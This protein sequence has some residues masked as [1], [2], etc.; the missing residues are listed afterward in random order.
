VG[1]LPGAADLALDGVLGVAGADAA[2][3]QLVARLGPFGNGNEE[4]LFVLPRVRVVKSERIGKDHATIRA[5]VAGEAGGQIKTLLFRAGEGALAAALSAVGGPP[6][7]LAG[8]LRAESWNGSVSAGFFV[9]D[10]APA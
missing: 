10:A 5:M 8:Y 6:L 1:E 2:L 7:H 3:A 4:P 9:A